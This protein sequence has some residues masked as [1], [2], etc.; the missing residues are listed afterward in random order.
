MRSMINLCLRTEYSFQKTYGFIEDVVSSQ[1]VAVGIADINNTFSH[2][3]LNKLCKANGKKPIFGIRLMVV[4]DPENDTEKQFGPE[5]IF[6][7]KNYEGLREIYKL[8]E[9]A[10]QCFYHFPRVGLVDVWTLSE[11]VIVIATHYELD[12][13]IDYIGVCNVTSHIALKSKIPKVAINNNW[14]L[15]AEDK[16][17]YQLFSGARKRENFTFPMHILSTEEW[18]FYFDNEEA[19][20][21]THEIA[22]ICNVD[23]PVGIP[24]RYKGNQKIRTLCRE[25]A[26]ER[27]IDLKDPIYRA[28][29]KREMDLIREKDFVDYFLIVHEMI[30]KAKK[31]MLVGPGR[32]SSGGSL[33]CF[34]LGITD[35][36]PIRWDL[37]FERFID[38]NRFDMPDIDIDFPDEKRHLVVKELIRTNGRNN[39]KNI[40]NVSRMKARGAIGEF[41]KCL[42]VP[43][44][45]VEELKR[46]IIN[47]SSGDVRYRVIAGWNVLGTKG[48]SILHTYESSEVGQKFL[49]RN[50]SMA[51]AGKVEGHS[52]HSSV[53]AAGIIVA[54]NPLSHYASVNPRDNTI[55]L[56]G[57]SAE[58]MG[59]LKIDCLGLSTL[60][61][62]EGVADLI[63][64][65][66]S[67]YNDINLDDD[68]V[69]SLF[70][71]RKMKGIFQFEG[72]A[73]EGLCRTIKVREFEDLVAITALARP[74]PL[75]SG[76][77]AKFAAIHSG[78]E[79][80]ELVMNDE[81]VRKVTEKT[82]GV[83]IYQ[84]QVM[85][86]MR[87]VAGM[88][89]DKVG[90]IRR[91]ISK[92]K[93]ADALKE[94]KEK[95][96]EGS[97]KRGIGRSEIEEAWE[98][99]L[100]F[101]QYG[102]NRSH[103]VAYSYISYWTAWAKFYH[104]I[105]FLASNLNHHTSLTSAKR[106]IREMIETHGFEFI[107]YDPEI[108]E[109]KWKIIGNKVI[110]PL[111]NI[112]GIGVKNAQV[113]M[114][115]RKT[116]EK[117]AAGITKKLENGIT[118]FDIIWPCN[119]YWGRLFKNPHRY[120]LYEKPTTIRNVTKS[121]E[122]LVV[123]QLIK[124]N[125]RDLN[126]LQ[127]VI[128]RGGETYGENTKL[129]NITVEDDTGSLMC[130]I[131]R[132]DYGKL[133]VEVAEDGEEGVDWY[134]I[135]GKIISKKIIFLFISEIHKLGDGYSEGQT[136]KD[137]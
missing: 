122:Y 7:A 41:S 67:G 111:T 127:N 12:E 79:K 3:Y 90:G 132:F 73:L 45:E 52:R 87:E 75:H 30:L 129:L 36:D 120:G 61:I 42:A 93:G 106:L 5:Y 70:R 29:F 49:E 95:F 108:S 27:G 107:P 66:Y 39:V 4:K 48:R 116:G 78:E 50:P 51:L 17:V 25:G 15:T 8:T 53:H 98:K 82:M 1:E 62:L 64:M 40:A 71:K 100:K 83:I 44:E 10:Y 96:I 13:R 86:I 117:F 99:I 65:R 126:E 72:Y 26:R 69:F 128:K 74:G 119:H 85:Q 60:S 84:E 77:A 31:T 6:L 56:E 14:T 88:P 43:D 76:G 2:F 63:G 37:L 16:E 91:A 124:K 137:L 34:L 131:N 54:T 55:Q 94:F 101:G 105:E 32:G 89:W 121:G 133:G 135:K 103:S 19:V 35:L 22:D 118:K 130:R 112:D 97:M 115:K 20:H 38:V 81:G 110:G 11:N 114:R 134:L 33:V 58:A 28:R 24:V 59:L 102:F 104:P 113:I 68:N 123:A 136:I 80:I 21:R 109:D 57:K 9:R 23:F 46:S 18:M 92:K 125:V 47:I